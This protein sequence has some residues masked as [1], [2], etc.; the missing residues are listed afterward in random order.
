MIKSK[1][2]HTPLGILFFLLISLSLNAQTK[3]NKGTEFLLG[4]MKHIDGTVAGMSLYITSDS[5]TSGT[6]S[7]PDQNWSTTFTVTANSVTV[8]NIDVPKAYVD[9]SDC[10]RSKGIRVESLKKVVVYAHHYQ[11]AR[12]D[13]TLVLPTATLG[14]EYYVMSYQEAVGSNANARSEFIVIADKDN[15]KVN[16]TPSVAIS[17]INGSTRPAN[18]TYQISLNAG[19]IYQGIASSG[20]GDLTGT[21]IEVIDTG[22]NSNCRTIAVFSGSS[23]TRISNNCTG[24]GTADNLTEQLYPTTSWGNRFVLV[25]ALGRSSDNFRFIAREDGTQIVITKSA[26]A[27][28]IAN[29]NRGQTYDLNDQSKVRNVVA[30]KPVMVAQ[31]QKTAR[32]DGLGNNSGDPSMTILNPLEQTLKDITLYSSQYYNITNHYI[33]VVIRAFYA[34]FI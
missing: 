17:R 27:P 7:M 14:N 9:C 16:I 25:P 33:N 23:F 22:I 8:V 28:D 3:S 11:G 4:F 12:S 6:V 24:A 21:H 10:I 34:P 26:G 32:C 30:N 5:N 31:F 15:T 13:A 18:T 20:S 29:I 2:Y 19:Q 1:K